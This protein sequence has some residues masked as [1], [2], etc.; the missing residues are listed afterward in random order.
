MRTAGSLKVEPFSFSRMATGRPRKL[1]PYHVSPG[2][3]KDVNTD[4][5]QKMQ[6][7]L[8]GNGERSIFEY[9]Q[10]GVRTS[11]GCKEEVID[12]VATNSLKGKERSEIVEWHSISQKAYH[13]VNNTFLE[14]APGYIQLP[15][16]LP[17][18]HH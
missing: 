12:N 13:N 8:F 2:H 7:Y 6:K 9:E 17:M 14:E 15:N 18:P 16:L 3:H 10:R 1:P 4:H 11:Q 5:A